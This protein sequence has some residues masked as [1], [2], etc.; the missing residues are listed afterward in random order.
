MKYTDHHV[1]TSFS[2]D[3]Q[4]SI[5]K[6]L[7][8]AKELGLESV[9]FTDHTDMGAIEVEFQKH[10]DYGD[11][12]SLMKRYEEEY[13]ID[14]K[15]GI[16]I[17]YEK[18]HKDQINDLLDKYPFDFVIASI[19]YGDGKDFYLGDFYEG[20]SQ[21]EAYMR[22]FEIL[23]EMVENFSNFDVVGHLDHIIRYGDYKDKT[24]AYEDYQEILD[25]ILKTIIEKSKGIE[26]NTSG[27][28]GELETTYPSQE[29][30][31]R[32]RQL[33]GRIITLGSDTHFNQ[34]YYK[35]ILEEIDNL[36]S[37][38]YEEI[39]SFKERRARQIVIK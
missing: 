19:H 36:K 2:P 32:Y 22:Y 35:G 26:V 11:Y 1:H 31:K 15:L 24:Y 9:I 29:V 8:R 20:K 25:K 3:S 30:L 28:R 17:G 16:E 12:M 5:E 37:L 38:G 18:S 21:R 33:G 27:L 14:I 7:V 6:Y 39:T 4:A 23:L 10:I 34:D 13:E